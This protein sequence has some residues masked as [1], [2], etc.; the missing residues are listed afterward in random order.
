MGLY[1]R[2]LEIKARLENWDPPI[3]LPE[4][5]L[6]VCMIRLLPRVFHQARYIIMTQKTITL[7]E[8]KEMLL[9]VENKDA[10]RIVAAVGSTG[11][12][13]PRRNHKAATALVTNTNTSKRKKKK[14]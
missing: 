4:K 1:G 2:V 14:K 7:N 6:M 10:E 9:D 3:V 13:A 11:A 12:S 5:L 8:S